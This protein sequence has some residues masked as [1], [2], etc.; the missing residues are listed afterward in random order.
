MSIAPSIGRTI[1]KEIFIKAMRSGRHM[2]TARPILP[3]MPWQAFAQLSDDDLR[4]IWEYLGTLPAVTNHV[5][6]AI[7]PPGAPG[8]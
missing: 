5:P 3:P 1:E 6:D 2:G 7:L 4:A 8:Q